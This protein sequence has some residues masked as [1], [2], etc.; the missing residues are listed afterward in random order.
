MLKREAV[1]R[2]AIQAFNE[3]GFHATSLDDVARRLNVTK[4][5]LYYYFASKDEIL[6]EAQR[7][8]MEGIRAAGEAAELARGDGLAKLRAVLFQYAVIMTMDVGMVVTRVGDHELSPQSRERFRTLKGGVDQM[9]RRLIDEGMRDGS[10]AP[11]DT[12]MIAFA[13]A[14]AVNWIGRWYDPNGPLTPEQIAQSFIA[15]LVDGIAAHP[16]RRAPLKRSVAGR[17]RVG[18]SR[19]SAKPA[20]APRSTPSDA[21]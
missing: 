13:L 4:P 17:S 11:G 3:K 21:P 5:T 10:I 2:A 8:G 9:L 19:K 6:F 20:R 1:L 18:T 12:R 7:L 16:V 15:T 14:G